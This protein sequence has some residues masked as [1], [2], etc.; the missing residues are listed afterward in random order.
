MKRLILTGLLICCGILG[1]E[2]QKVY[3]N[4]GIFIIEC[5]GM[6]EGSYTKLAKPRTTD[7]T[8]ST[9]GSL[10]MLVNIGAPLNDDKVAY[11]F[12]VASADSSVAG[13]DWLAGVNVCAGLSGGNWRLPTK[14]ELTLIWIQH[15]KLKSLSGFTP[16]VESSYWG[17]TEFKS[18]Q[19]YTHS[20]GATVG[21]GGPGLKTTSSYKVRCIRDITN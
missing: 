20:F 1:A 6:P 5:A 11:K 16:L 15:E 19:S 3:K 21:S 18:T 13:Y 8:N 10:D 9:Q 2:A 14:R 4:A 7:G 17:A 12:E